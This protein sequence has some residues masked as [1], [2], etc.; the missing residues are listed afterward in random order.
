M[1]MEKVYTKVWK[2]QLK[3]PVNIPKSKVGKSVKKIDWSFKMMLN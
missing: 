1:K 2:V 3:V